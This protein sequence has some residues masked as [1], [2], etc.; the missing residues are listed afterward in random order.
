MKKK[1]GKE[2]RTVLRDLWANIMYQHS[3]YRGPSKR[4]EKG[5]EKISEEIVA[6]NFP[7]RGKETQYRKQSKYNIGIN[8]RRNKPR[9]ILI[10]LTKIKDK[11]KMSTATSE[12]QQISYKGT[13][14]RLLAGFSAEILQARV[15]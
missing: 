7:N 14:I 6:E 8:P 1:E 4:R 5:P 13:P 2:M 10:K 11:E 15:A 3:H 9:H 12:K